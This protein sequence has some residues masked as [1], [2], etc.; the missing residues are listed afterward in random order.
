VHLGRCDTG[1]LTVQGVEEEVDT[2]ESVPVPST[3]DVLE[4]EAVPDKL[5]LDEQRKAKK[6]KKKSEKRPRAGMPRSQRGLLAIVDALSPYLDLNV[7]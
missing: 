3:H 1:A 2:G 4:H 7:L 6:E 5:G